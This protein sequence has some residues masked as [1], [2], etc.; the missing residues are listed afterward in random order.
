M[1]GGHPAKFSARVFPVTAQCLGKSI[2]EDFRI[3][4]AM[5][6]PKA[7]HSQI[8]RVV[9]NGVA[10][11]TYKRICSKCIMYSMLADALKGRL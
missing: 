2:L 10:N 3:G 6:E 1:R 4:G 9:K 11:T 8:L 5:T 7:K